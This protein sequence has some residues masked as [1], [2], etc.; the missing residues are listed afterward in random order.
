MFWV[1]FF[2]TVLSSQS[3][4]DPVVSTHLNPSF[5]VLIQSSKEHCAALS[6]SCKPE[7]WSSPI[8]EAVGGSLLSVLLW[9]LC[10]PGATFLGSA[11]LVVGPRVHHLVIFPGHFV[12]ILDV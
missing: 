10:W 7:L 4:F 12:V 2:F 1:F 6:P 11:G 8:C 9:F 3:T 5:P